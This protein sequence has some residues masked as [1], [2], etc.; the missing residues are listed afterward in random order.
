MA[1]RLH[2]LCSY[3]LLLLSVLTHAF[4]WHWHSLSLESLLRLFSLPRMLFFHLP[5]YLLQSLLECHLLNWT[6]LTTIFKPVVHFP[7]VPDPLYPAYFPLVPHGTNNFLRYYIIHLLIMFIAYCLCSS[8][9]CPKVQAPQKQVS[10]SVLFTK[11]SE[12]RRTV[13]SSPKKY[14]EHNMCSINT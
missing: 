7:S 3:G 11:V 10:L 14:L 2:M 6:I 12:A 5:I 9:F 4:Q 8:Y 1:T 13:P